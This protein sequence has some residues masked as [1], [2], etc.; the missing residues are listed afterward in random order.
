MRKTAIFL[1]ALLVLSVGGACVAAAGVYQAHDQVVLTETVTYG[2]RTAADGLTVVSRTEYDGHL[3]WDTVCTLDDGLAA[4]SDYAFSAARVSKKWKWRFTGVNLNTASG[5]YSSSWEFPETPTGLERAY[6]EL[7]DAVG[8]GEE[9]TKEIVL[10]DYV[11]RYPVSVELDFPDLRG[12]SFW[13]FTE[14]DP[15]PGTEYDAAARLEEYFRIPVLEGERREI[16]IEK[17]SDGTVGGA[18]ISSVG[19]C[20]GMWTY[21][22]LTDDACYFT[23]DTHSSEGRVVDTSEIPGGYGIYRL[24]YE[25]DRHDES[26]QKVCSVDVDGLEMVCP[27]DPEVELNGLTVNEKK[28][29]LILRA[30]EDGEDVLTVIDLETFAVRQKLPLGESLYRLY[31]E[32]DFLVAWTG[33][34]L[35]VF[36]CTDGGDYALEFTCAAAPEGESLYDRYPAWDFDGEKLVLADVLEREVK[37]MGWTQESCGFFVQVYDKTGLLYRGEYRSSLDTGE[38]SLGGYDCLHRGDGALSVHWQK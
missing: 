2:D 6:K 1:A 24:P 16:S 9:R 10:S 20:F 22:A 4:K 32:G 27:L 19:D 18:G 30:V 29:R 31:D 26:G 36:S 21:S 5:W 8:P 25:E 17:Y 35:T 28:D 14:G 15:E 37:S 7:S 12:Y 38:S 11:D 23:F 34:N 33:E 13:P 3:F